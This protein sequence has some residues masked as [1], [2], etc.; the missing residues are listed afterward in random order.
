MSASLQE[1]V[2]IG[3]PESARSYLDIERIIDAAKRTGAE[4]IHPGYGFLAE[5]AGFARACAD[6]DIVF[7]G[8]PPAAMEAVGEKVRARETMIAAGR[9]RRARA[10]RR[11]APT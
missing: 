2:R 4:A 8:P 11:S 9:A 1:A 10:R 6:A 7:I 3:P 5:N